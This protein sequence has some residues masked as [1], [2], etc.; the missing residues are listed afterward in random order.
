MTENPVAA[1][2]RA[3]PTDNPTLA[4]MA[5]HRSVRHFAPVPLSRDRLETAVRAAQ[6]AATSSHVQAYG[7]IHVTDPAKRER[8]AGLTGDQS[9]VAEAGAFL[10]FCADIRRHQLLAKRAAHPHIQN[11]ESFLVATIDTALF[12]QNLALAFES[13]GL[14]ICYIGGLRNHLPAVD[15]LL[16]LPDG[17]LPLFGMCVGEPARRPSKKPRLPLAAVLFENGYPDDEAMLTHLDGYDD[18]LAEYYAERGA[19]GRNWSRGIVRKYEAP[20]RSRLAAYYRGK[21][22]VLE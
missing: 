4:L 19:A 20:R 14:G 10:V 13:M 2:S 21:G 3:S 12:A 11:L 16:N 22:A 7:L 8:L 6:M 18:T 5:D 9:M 17:V 15:A 1:E